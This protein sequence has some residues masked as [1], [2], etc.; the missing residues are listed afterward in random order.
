MTL[1]FGAGDR[2]ALP[3]GDLHLPHLVSWI[4]ERNPRGTDAHMQELLE[5]Y[6]GHRFRVVRLLL[7]SRV[8]VPRLTRE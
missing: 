5:P 4:F 8:S 1:G 7:S 3:L 2:D 6:A